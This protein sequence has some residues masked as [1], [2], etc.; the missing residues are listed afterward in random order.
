[1]PETFQIVR[2]ISEASQNS[3][4]QAVT[5]TLSPN[6]IIQWSEHVPH[7]TLGFFEKSEGIIFN[8]LAE[9]KAMHPSTTE[10]RVPRAKI[11]SNFPVGNYMLLKKYDGFVLSRGEKSFIARLYETPNDYPVVEAEFGLEE[12]SDVD[13]GLVVEGAALVW[14]IGYHDESSRKRESLIYMRRQPAWDA[15]E[16]KHAIQ[17]AED[18]TRDIQWK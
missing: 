14:T 1:M 11:V 5:R 18:L 8:N 7:A 10:V 2:G 16:I 12:L 3:S 9:Q 15:K 6:D 13:R 17:A 4:Q